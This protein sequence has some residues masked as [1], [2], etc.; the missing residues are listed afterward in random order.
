M[1]GKLMLLFFVVMPAVVTFLRG[2]SARQPL[3]RALLLVVGAG[4]AVVGALMLG[5]VLLCSGD[6][7][8]G[9]SGCGAAPALNAIRP[10]VVT[11]GMICLFAG[12]PL[13]GLALWL[14]RRVV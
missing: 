7:L 4:A 8:V 13:A 2:L 5:P 9:W 3:A 12:P 14:E 10:T 6:P 1:S 11:L